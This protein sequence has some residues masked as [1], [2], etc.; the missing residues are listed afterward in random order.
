M[1]SRA[2]NGRIVLTPACGMPDERLSGKRAE[3]YVPS[4]DTEYDR[5]HLCTEDGEA[6][7]IP[8]TNLIWKPASEAR[9]PRTIEGL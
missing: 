9:R 1:E 3:V 5:V 2:L 7:E 8:F 6:F 4:D